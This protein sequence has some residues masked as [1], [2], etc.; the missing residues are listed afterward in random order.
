M[1]ILYRM[2]GGVGHKAVESFLLLQPA[3][4]LYALALTR[5]WILLEAHPYLRS[6]SPAF[7]WGYFAVLL[8]IV[9]GALMRADWS[10]WLLHRMQ[11]P[12]TSIRW[13]VRLAEGLGYQEK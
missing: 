1:V 13:V 12:Y 7:R 2:C 3:T 4:L 5:S 10:L 11:V 9:V 6:G 8:G